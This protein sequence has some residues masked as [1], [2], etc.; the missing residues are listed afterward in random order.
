[1][2]M[3]R[4]GS[5]PSTVRTTRTNHLSNDV[6]TVDTV[7]EMIRVAKQSSSDEVV[8]SAVQMALGN[9]PVSAS[10]EDQVEAIFNWVQH[11]IKFVEDGEVLQELFGLDDSKADLIIAPPRLLT[12]PVPAGDCDC[13]STLLASMLLSANKNVGVAFR[14]TASDSSR[15]NDYSHVY[16]VATLPCGR[17]VPLD[18]SHG[19]YAGWE[20]SEVYRKQTYS[21]RKAK[22]MP[23]QGLG[24]TLP[25]YAQD[26]ITTGID[27]TGGILTNRYGVPPVGTTIQTPEG[28]IVRQSSYPGFGVS[29]YPGTS[30]AGGNT[31]MILGVGVVALMIFMGRK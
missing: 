12:M 28:T 13:F 25:S 17:E 29:T 27:L 18:A 6:S 3:Q 23:I 7:R 30:L 11:N 4:F 16:V 10:A 31:W 24:F 8:G 21:V 15:P 2:P 26:W 14:T 22:C 19:D 1:M 5:I 9:L 20:T